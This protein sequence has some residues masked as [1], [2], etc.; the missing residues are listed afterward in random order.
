V[1]RIDCHERLKQ[2]K[3]SYEAA[4]RTV[5]VLISVVREQPDYLYNRSLDLS[6]MRGL[7][8]ELHDVYFVRMFSSFESCIRHFWRAV[9]RDTKP[10]TQQLVASVAARRGVP[11]DTQD[12]VQ[13]IR[14]FRNFLIHEEH[15][16]KKRFT[17]DEAS[18]HLNTYL[19]RLPLEW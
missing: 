11:E 12:A 14:E 9:V 8:E 6:E 13:E 2:V 3:R 19:A 1:R 15:E 5:Q 16:A 4:L 17:I 10:V 7:A 18:K